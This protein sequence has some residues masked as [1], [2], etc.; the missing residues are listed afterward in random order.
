[1][2][3]QSGMKLFTFIISMLLVCALCFA[4]SAE[5]ADSDF[6]IDGTTLVKYKGFKDVVTVPDGITEIGESAFC[7]STATKIILPETLEEIR[8]YAFGNCYNLKEITLPASLTNLEYEYDEQYS[9]PIIQACV[10]GNNEKL[11]AINVAE[12]NA[13]YTSIDG[14]LFTADGKKL[15]Y[16]PAGKNRYKSYAIPEGT[17]EIGY[18]A[19]S[20]VSLSSIELPSTL[21][22]LHDE[23]GDFSCISGLKEITVNSDKSC[24]YSVDGVLYQ[25]NGTLV[26]Y[27]A[28]KK[29][30]VL[31]KED[32][33][34]G[35]TN[36]GA[37]AFQG[38]EYLKTIELPNTIHSVDWMAFMGAHSL[39]SV[40]FP[41]ATDFI[42]GYAFSYCQNLKKVTLPGQYVYFPEDSWGEGTN[43]ANVFS[44]A[45]SSVVLCGTAGSNVQTFAEKW[46][47]EF[48]ALNADDSSL[49]TA[50]NSEDI[51]SA[52][53]TPDVI[54][55]QTEEGKIT[56][57]A[58][59]EVE[60]NGFFET[61]G[62]TLVR[63]TGI[64]EEVVIV[65]DG[66]E[67]LGE[68]AFDRCNARKIILP[69]SL[70]EI[71]CYCFF[72]CPNLADITLPAS[73]ETLG[74]MQAFNITPALKRFKV[75]QGNKNFVSVDGVLFSADR[76]TLLYY[77][78]GKNV[79]GTYAI[80]EGTKWLGGAAL[81][82]ARMSV[83]EI[84]ASFDGNSFY[85]DFS[86]MESLTDINVSPDNKTCKSI[87]GMLFDNDGTLLAYPA[88]RKAEHLGK[89]DFPAEMK[90]LA[91]WAFQ[92]V[93][94]LKTV[95]IPD[96]ITTIPWM[97]FTFTDCLERVTL[98]AS[99][100]N[101]S[102]YAFADNSVLKSLTVLNPEAVLMEDDENFSDEYRAKMDFNI[103][104]DS[105]KATL[106]GY[107][108]STAQAYAAKYDLAFESLG[109]A[110]EKDPNAPAP[111]PMPV[112]VP[113]CAE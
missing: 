30:E 33:P 105:P 62:T 83:V 42:S 81:G 90:A 93:Q 86:S 15:L 44:D 87:D 4:V 45:N 73:L 24:F 40:T 64:D 47:I 104:D 106:R 50:A 78:D 41:A 19:F 36:I 17:E 69:E 9:D 113:G 28:S 38:N 101:I 68:F 77:P 109:E 7:G 54:V 65:P 26:L 75:A 82:A 89:D 88:G 46:G 43:G 35:L 57:P 6:E 112:F 74:S 67:V 31:K 34:R 70:K 3:R 99:V 59:P 55:L 56:V 37:F 29:G 84:P 60:V 98:P 107:E 97:C 76:E 110:P 18:S 58:E 27:P 96:G 95:E 53:P 111:E 39:E 11:E 8:S 48:E 13:N 63:Y 92:H 79:G 12:G 49:Q 23:G 2:E 10:F 51:A 32:F 52:V 72:N 103:L 25:H 61:S 20:G 1:M 100:C 85:N 94:H 66:I 108:G 80:P 22:T 21:T 16:Y 102:G 71:Q 14:V 91:P 5:S